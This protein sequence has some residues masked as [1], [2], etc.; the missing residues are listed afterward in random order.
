MLVSR[1]LRSESLGTLASEN[2][3][4]IGAA[5]VFAARS[6]VPAVEYWCS[7]VG[8]TA[9]ESGGIVVLICDA[10]LSEAA[11]EITEAMQAEPVRYKDIPL[12][13]QARRPVVE[14]PQQKSD[15]GAA[16]ATRVWQGRVKVNLSFDE[17]GYNIVAYNA[18]G[19]T[20][21]TGSTLRVRL[22]EFAICGI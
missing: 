18:S 6:R 21:T 17:V 1:V 5:R 15:V 16:S 14:L 20:L 12:A 4:I 22:K 10:S 2:A 13:E 19:A 7:I 3:A 8:G 9:A 11:G